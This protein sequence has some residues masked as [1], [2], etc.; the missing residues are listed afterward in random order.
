VLAAISTL[1]ASGQEAWLVLGDMAELGPGASVLHAEIGS[2]AKAAGLARLWTVGKLSRSASA[3]FGPGAAHFESQEAL[4]AALR[5]ALA[6]RAEGALRVLVKGSR[7][8]AMDKVVGALLD[9]AAQARG[10]GGHAA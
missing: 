8:S 7:S 4:V 5:E 1:A 9:D 10:E 2:Q 6:T 3:A